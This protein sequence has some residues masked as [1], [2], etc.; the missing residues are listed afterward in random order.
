MSVRV[1]V[2]DVGETII[3]ESRYRRRW[4]DWLG[5]SESAFLQ[6]MHQAIAQGIEY[7]RIFR[8]FRPDFDLAAARA[9]MR[10][11]HG[12]LPFDA[13]DLFADS[14][15]CLDELSRRGYRIG[16]VGN[17]PVE[18]EAAMQALGL[19]IDFMASSARW[20]V[21]KPEPAFFA[22]VIE[23][24]GAAAAEIAY[25]GDRVDNDVLPARAAGLISVFLRRG[26][27]AT[28][29]A[30]LAEAAQAHLTLD[31]LAELPDAL[32]MLAARGPERKPAPPR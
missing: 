20:G 31:S 29:Q 22:R 24:A 28:V 1:V 19:P 14:R 8:Q 32:G 3:D 18:A 9:E 4:A 5:V 30:G 7:G 27:W 26:P 12:P 17:Q 11:R 2:F 15:G 16:V 25:V 6:A 23:A 13:D 10:A 21:R